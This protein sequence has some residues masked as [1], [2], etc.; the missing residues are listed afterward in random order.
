VW[1]ETFQKALA[2]EVTSALDLAPDSWDADLRLYGYNAILGDLD[3]APAT[4]REVGVMLLVS[5]A[6]QKTAT[7]ISKVANP[8]LLH[9]PLPTMNYLPSLAFAT[10]PAHIE[11]GAT[12]EFVLNHVVDVDAPTELFRIELRE[13]SHA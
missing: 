7:A 8:L 1:A 10:S 2:R 5:A 6:D 9:L 11:R 12:Y 4:P 3:P 13:P